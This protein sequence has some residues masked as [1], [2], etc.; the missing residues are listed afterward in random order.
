[1]NLFSNFVGDEDAETGFRGLRGVAGGPGLP[2]DD[3]ILT[4]LESSLEKGLSSCGALIGEPPLWEGLGIG[5]QG[6]SPK[7]EDGKGDGSV[8]N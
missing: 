5:P 2:P 8:D 3:G 6:F 4:S 7:E 1:M